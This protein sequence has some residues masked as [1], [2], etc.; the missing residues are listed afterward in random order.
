MRPAVNEEIRWIYSF[1]NAGVNH[2][3]VEKMTFNFLESKSTAFLES[4]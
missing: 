1:V 4:N 3:L 2:Y